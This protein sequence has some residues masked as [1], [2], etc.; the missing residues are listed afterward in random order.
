MHIRNAATQM[1][2]EMGFGKGYK[3][4]HD[5][6]GNYVPEDYLP[7]ELIGSRF[8]KASNNGAEVAA[9]ARLEE[10]RKPRK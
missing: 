2:A 4:P 3:Y 9:A 5:F 8:Y 6:A 10:Q 7:R 1:M